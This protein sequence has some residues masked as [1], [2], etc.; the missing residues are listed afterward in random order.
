MR[1]SFGMRKKA[2][3]IPRLFQANR[4][5][6]IFIIRIMN[7]PIIIGRMNPEPLVNAIW[8]PA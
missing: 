1:L 7:T 5:N 3:R 8:A 4:S 2:L 6:N